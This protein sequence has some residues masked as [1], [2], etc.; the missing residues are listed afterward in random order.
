M[1]LRPLPVLGHGFADAGPYPV[2]LPVLLLVAGGVLFGATRLRA[3]V[4][5]GDDVRPLVD[6]AGRGPRIVLRVLAMLLMVAIIV[7]AALGPPDV[8]LNPAPRL[9]FT[10]GWAGLLL[11][12]ALLGPV[13]ESA[14]PLRWA[15]APRSPEVPPVTRAGMW[16]AVGALVLFTI[17]EQVLEPR[18]LLVLVVVAVYVLATMAGAILSGSAWFSGVDP[19]D[20]ASYLLGRLAPFGRRSGRFTLRNVRD[21]VAG[22][23]MVPGI[24]AFCG[25]L[26]AASAFDAAAPDGGL[27]ARL[28]ILVLAAAAAAG[29]ATVAG[30][31]ADLGVALIPAAASHVAAHYLA[32]LLVDTQAAAVQASDPLGLGWNLLGLTGSEIVA[33]P[34]PPVAGLT[35]AYLLLLGGHALAVVVATDLATRRVAPRAVNATLFGIRAAIALSLFVGV[36]LRLGGT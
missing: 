22:T 5:G 36:Y 16:P 32:P 9:L 4:A 28:L 12:S 18:P 27:A 29:V 7:P 26:I 21:G 20:R 14:N 15:A 31:S 8:S 30:R 33:E 1:L 25:V 3:R 24:A 19:I 23:D 2:P 10:V 11:A 34:I 35:L 6:G 13:W 17:A